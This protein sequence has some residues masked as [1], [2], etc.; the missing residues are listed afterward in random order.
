MAE[1]VLLNVSG[2]S[3][4]YRSGGGV[5]GIDFTVRAG[6]IVV[7]VGPNGAGKTTTLRCIAGL[8]QPD[9]GDVEVG[10]AGL[11]TEL[12]NNVAFVQDR[13]A[14]YPA[15]TV[16]EHLRFRAQL[17]E[18]APDV[19]GIVRDAMKAVGLDD[20][21]DRSGS[22][23]SRGQQQRVVL[24]AAWMQRAAVQVFDEPT[25]GLDPQSA[26]WLESWIVESSEAGAA[27]VVATH[28]L[29]L[30]VRVASRVLVVKD[31]RIVDTVVS[32]RR[33]GQTSDEFRSDL[34]SVF[35]T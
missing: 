33:S 3:K 25:S 17:L 7:L 20:L 18:V 14:L 13:P 26:A 19:D 16:E 24:A 4:A 34:M 31:G 9:S 10:T 28:N 5:S 11:D 8:L 2:L 32:P 6:E 30:A 22:E 29:D 35:A 12:A 1:A 27:V 21:N 23:L 15:L